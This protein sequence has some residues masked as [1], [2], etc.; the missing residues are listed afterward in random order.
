MRYR[1]L[2]AAGDK[3]ILESVRIFLEKEYEIVVAFDG[4]SA[5]VK[6]QSYEPDLVIIDTVFLPY[7]NGFKLYEA[8]RH[9]SKT[10]DVKVIFLSNNKDALQEQNEAYYIINFSNLLALENSIKKLLASVPKTNKTLSFQDI[11]SLE[12]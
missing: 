3:K 11:L 1:I 5:L 2:I 9:S 6:A 4:F 8:L 12:T 10:R 7:L